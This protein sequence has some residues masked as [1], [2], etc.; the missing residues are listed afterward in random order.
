[1]S[2]SGGA[3]HSTAFAAGWPKKIGIIQRGLLPDVGEGINGS[4]VVAPV[5]C[6]DGGAGM[7]IGVAPDAGPAYIF[8]PNGSSCYGTD[9]SGRDNSLETDFSAGNGQ[10]DH[11]AFAAV[12]Y[13]AFGTFGGKN[14]DFFTP[15][16][17]LIRALDVAVN[18]Y[19][20]G[21]DFI[22]G[23]NPANGQALPGYPAE[24]NDL[25]F[26]T[27]PVIGQIT[28]RGGQAVIGGTA[29]LDLAAFNRT[30]LPAS[31]S[32]PKLTGDWTIATPTL[33]SLGTL[34]IRSSARKEVVSIT[35]TGTL[36]VYSTAA[37][38][39][40]PSSSPRFH[41]DDWNSGN[42][43][44]D[45]VP[46][47]KPFG[48]RLRR[49]ILRFRA[50]GDNLLCG[51]AARYQ[52]VTSNRRITPQNFAHAKRLSGAPRPRA[53]GSR[54]SFGLPAGAGRYI[55]IRAVDAAGNVGLPM[56]IRVGGRRRVS[57]VLTS[58]HQR[59]APFSG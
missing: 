32:W 36:S 2:C 30:G 34:D 12:G 31:G 45:A 13:P 17:G 40:S 15:Q 10:Y 5:R 22:G 27:G 39:C 25:Q 47:G 11:P 52:L 21:Q 42:Y 28:V 50:P 26:L 19:Q 29:S 1:M 44:T 4:P 49:R 20:G 3:C 58:R 35:R 51:T 24:V 16:A 53:A 59:G 9:Q 8:N 23:W 43:T 46:P 56:V 33:G 37:P 38:A 41:H 7:K 14:I 18:D 48:A 55:A 6:P 57:S 54:Q